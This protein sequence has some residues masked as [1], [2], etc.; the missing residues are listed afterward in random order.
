MSNELLAQSLEIGLHGQTV[1][2]EFK[3]AAKTIRLSKEDPLYPAP[4]LAAYLRRE[5]G[6]FEGRHDAKAWMVRAL[7]YRRCAD[8]LE[9]KENV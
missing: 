9:G 5:A 7:V 8:I 1:P 3:R 2:T 4:V 6:F